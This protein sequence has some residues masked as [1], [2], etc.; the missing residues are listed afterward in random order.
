MGSYSDEFRAE[1]VA[2]LIA[3]GYPD[4]KGSLTRVSGAFGIPL[5]TASRWFHGSSNPP[6]NEIVSEKGA[7]LSARLEAI[8]HQLIDAI[9]NKIDDATLQQTTTSLAIAVDKMRLLR[10]QATNIVDDATLTDTGRTERL[11]QLLNAAR[12]R[13]DGQVD[14]GDGRSEG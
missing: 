13:R 9:P 2:E 6:P 8:A 4:R 11:A 5:T 10:E 3:E 7:E 14:T 1:V 12:D